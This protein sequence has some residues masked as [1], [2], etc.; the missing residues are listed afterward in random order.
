MSAVRENLPSTRIDSQVPLAMNKNIPA[1]QESPHLLRRLFVRDGWLANLQVRLPKL[2]GEERTVSRFYI[3][4]GFPIDFTK[5]FLK[6]RRRLHSAESNC[7][8][9]LDQLVQQFSRPGA[10]GDHAEG[11]LFDSG[12]IINTDNGPALVKHRSSF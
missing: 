8:S 4:A 2:K 12:A 3:P 1:S 10:A 11:K 5:D 6:N 7:T 9:A